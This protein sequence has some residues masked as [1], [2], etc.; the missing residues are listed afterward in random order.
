MALTTSKGMTRAAY[1][2]LCRTFPYQRPKVNATVAEV[3]RA[4]G[5]R[6]ILEWLER[7]LVDA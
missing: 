6:D 5:Q 1:E 2:A 4:E 7:N 3:Q